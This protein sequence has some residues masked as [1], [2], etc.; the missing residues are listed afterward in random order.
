V[1][2]GGNRIIHAEVQAKD[3]LQMGG[4]PAFM[5]H[6][7]RWPRDIRINLNTTTSDWF[8]LADRYI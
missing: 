1:I 2:L 4:A 8:D 7:E 3:M 6:M 5:L